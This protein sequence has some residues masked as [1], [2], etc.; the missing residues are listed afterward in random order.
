MSTARASVIV[1]GCLVFLTLTVGA[2]VMYATGFISGD[3]LGG[4]LFVSMFWAVGIA[5][6]ADEW[7]AP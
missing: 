1:S 5:V 7:G 2:F 6:C 4:C 3:A